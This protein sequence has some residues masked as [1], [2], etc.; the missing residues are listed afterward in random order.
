MS[1]TQNNIKEGSIKVYLLKGILY[2]DEH[3]EAWNNLLLFRA[4]VVDWFHQINLDIFIDETEGYAFLKQ[5]E[6]FEADEVP[7][8][9]P[10]LI[11]RRSLS[12]GVSLLCVLLH[13]KLVEH[14]THQSGACIIHRSEI[15]ETMTVFL[16]GT[17][18]EAKIVDDI[19]SYIKKVSTSLGFLRSLRGE[20]EHYE[21]RRIIK[22]FV[23]A[24]NLANFRD[25]LMNVRNSKRTEADVT[26]EEKEV[27]SSRPNTSVAEPL[28][29]LTSSTLE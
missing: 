18:S 12:Y 4:S 13:K 27:S 22:A 1:Q 9:I 17:K 11:I 26:P 15:I 2:R 29:W 24:Q 21:I 20:Q 28:A 6:Y 10:P 5:K 14:E 3:S 23:N 7:M 19:N 8:T 16:A 25:A